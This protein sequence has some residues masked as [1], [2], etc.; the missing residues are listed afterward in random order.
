MV[1]SR[2]PRSALFSR[3]Q[4]LVAATVF[5]LVYCFLRVASTAWRRE[6]RIAFGDLSPPAPCFVAGMLTVRSFYHVFL[7]GLFGDLEIKLL[8]R[9]KLSWLDTARGEILES[10]NDWN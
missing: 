8:L 4:A 6:C 3:V 5:L 9:R 10:V 1:V 2:V 7:A